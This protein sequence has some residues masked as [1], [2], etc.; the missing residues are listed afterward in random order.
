MGLFKTIIGMALDIAQG[1]TWS[2]ETAEFTGVCKDKNNN[3]YDKFVPE[4]TVIS[5]Y[6]IT[7]HVFGRNNRLNWYKFPN[8]EMPDPAELAGSTIAIRYD[9]EDPFFYDA[10][11]EVRPRGEQIL[12]KLPE[13]NIRFRIGF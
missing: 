5:E 9:E 7:Y 13:S 10:F 12:P 6:Q 1:R 3:I 8:G 4:G 11:G 2:F